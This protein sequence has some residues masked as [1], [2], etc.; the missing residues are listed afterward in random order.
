MA[1]KP[2]NKGKTSLE[3]D[4]VVSS[5][6][7]TGKKLRDFARKYANDQF[8]DFGGDVS[9]EIIRISEDEFMRVVNWLKEK[10]Y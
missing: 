1:E 9:L 8:P 4:A 6:M 3:V 5:Q 2:K 7:P 10:G